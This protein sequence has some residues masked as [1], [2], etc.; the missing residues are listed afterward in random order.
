M[1]LLWQ[2]PLLAP[3]I[4]RQ[5]KALE[6]VE[7]IRRTTEELIARCCC[8]Q[9]CS[10]QILCLKVH[11]LTAS[12]ITVGRGLDA[13][14]AHRAEKH[15]ALLHRCKAM[16]DAEEAERGRVGFEEGYLNEADPSV[17]RFLIA[18]RCRHPQLATHR[19][20]SH[21]RWCCNA[22]QEGHRTGT[23]TAAESQISGDTE[24][25]Q[26]FMTAV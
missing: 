8:Q 2:V 16:V 3:L 9:C 7:L 1:P 24:A 18:S 22:R 10:C 26:A 5:R 4:P 23:I 20:R 17:L 25:M 15:L 14:Q 6:A 13:S 12:L 11:A 19:P 21:G